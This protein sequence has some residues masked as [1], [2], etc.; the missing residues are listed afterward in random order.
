M[1][2]IRKL[3]L[4]G[5]LSLLFLLLYKSSVGM[6]I[7]TP[8]VKVGIAKLTGTITVQN[9]TSSDSIY[10]NITVPHPISGEFVKYKALVD[11]TGKFAIDVDVETS[12]CLTRFYTS[13]DPDKALLVKLK[14]GDLTNINLAYDSSFGIEHVEVTPNMNKYDVLRCF[15]LIG[16]MIEFKSDNFLDSP[17]DK[18]TDYF[19]EYTESVLSERLTVVR[20]DALISK[21][22]KEILSKDFQLFLYNTSVFDYAGKMK[23][24]Y[25]ATNGDKNTEPVI[26]NID[27]LFFRFLKDSNL[28]DPQYLYI[29]TFLE[30]QKSIL[31]DR[32]LGLPLIG[33]SD[34]PS[35]LNK[36]K[37]ILS[38]L[39][40]FKDGQYYDILA[41]NAYGIQLNEQIRPLSQIQKENI[42]KYWKDGDIAKILFRKDLQV[43]GLDKYKSPIVIN[44][45]LSIPNDKVIETIVS[46]YKNK[47][48]LID[49]WAT[50]CIPC[51]TAIQEFRSAKGEFHDK[52]V[53]FVYLTNS[54]SP[55][56]V[57]E[58]KIKGIGSEHY[59]LNDSQWE[60]VMG[61]FGFEYIPSYL[62]YNKKGLLIKKKSAFPGSDKVKDMINGL[63]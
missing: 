4:Y 29:F 12:I 53:V 32:T 22:L 27:R 25:R 49:L 18:P 23:G 35:W 55:R 62:L 19:L 58:E 57:W 39:V 5:V 28:N 59:Y 56:N 31:Q 33:D 51:L 44:D 46:K 8:V 14:S 54:S 15:G 52:D 21:E 48:V 40:G 6:V 45:I 37:A 11:R 41:A 7:D 3:H 24:N 50:W 43:V 47:V 63:L 2:K 34:I 1:T 9:N 30:F 38:D 36:V 10:V 17:Y 61:H 20:N 60:Y 42:K 13:L 26:Q 16:E